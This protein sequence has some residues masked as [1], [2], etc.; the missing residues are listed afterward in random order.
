MSKEK[1]ATYLGIMR[2]RNAGARKKKSRGLVLDEYCK[3]TERTRKHA[4]FP[5]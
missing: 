1:R 3:V 5:T 4:M 2:R